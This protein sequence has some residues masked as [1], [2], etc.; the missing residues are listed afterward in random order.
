[1]SRRLAPRLAGFEYRGHYRYFVTIC[2]RERRRLFVAPDVVDLLVLQ[3]RHAA[4]MTEMA[5]PAYCVMPDHVHILAEGTTASAD[6]REFVRL[7]KQTSSFAYARTHGAHLWQRGYFERVLRADEDSVHVTRYIMENPVRAGLV[8]DA[9]AYPFS[10][11][12][13]LDREALVD[14]TDLDHA[15]GQRGGRR[16]GA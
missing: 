10:G 4:A 15:R 3:L 6:F 1:M 2:T 7:F 16:G 14:S 11:S 12:L 13:T 8:A 9:L 5:V